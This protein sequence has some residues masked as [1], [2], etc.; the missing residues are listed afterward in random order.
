MVANYGH[1]A[2][3]NLRQ[4]I[5][6][7]NTKLDK[8]YVTETSKSR[9]TSADSTDESA[10]FRQGQARGRRKTKKLIRQYINR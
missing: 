6:L 7:E 2:L 10:M 5:K 3:R 9:R 1:M 8:G 4:N